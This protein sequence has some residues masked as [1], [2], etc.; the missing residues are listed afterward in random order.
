MKNTLV[1]RVIGDEYELRNFSSLRFLPPSNFSI[2]S[3]SIWKE[4]R[5]KW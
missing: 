5:K 3:N 2:W 1:Q 4:K